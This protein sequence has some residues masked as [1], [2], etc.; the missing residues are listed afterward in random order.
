M[1]YLTTP[2]PLQ[3]VVGLSN[4]LYITGSCQSISMKKCANKELYYL[5]KSPN[6]NYAVCVETDVCEMV[7]GT[8]LEDTWRLSGKN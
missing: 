2:P 5:N 6:A 4:T 8:P 3:V 1:T 7:E